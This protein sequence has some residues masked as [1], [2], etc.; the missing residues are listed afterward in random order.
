MNLVAGIL[1]DRTTL[2]ANFAQPRAA[3][4]LETSPITP[5]TNRGLGVTDFTHFLLLHA[6]QG[7]EG[8]L[9]STTQSFSA[10]Q[11]APVSRASA[12]VALAFPEL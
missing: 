3:P 5:A 10:G 2:R 11:V 8:T 7:P 4:I 6:S 9:C 1:H 12:K